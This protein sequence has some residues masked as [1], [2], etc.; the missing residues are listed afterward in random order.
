[1]KEGVETAGVDTDMETKKHY[2]KDL[3]NLH[4]IVNL[5]G[6]IESKLKKN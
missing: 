6:E 1:M 4:S 2:H 3:R 5:K